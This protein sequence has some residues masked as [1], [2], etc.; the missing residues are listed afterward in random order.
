M[1]PM[2]EY[3]PRNSGESFV[4]KY[5]DYDFFPTPWHFHPEYE[6]VQVIESTGMRF[7][8]DH[9][10]EF[11]PGDMVLI[12]PYL[13]HTY[14]ND[15]NYHL[16]AAALRAKSIVI[17]FREDSFGDNFLGL[18]ETQKVSN[19]LLRSQKG[20]SITGKTNAMVSAK[21]TELL[22]AKGLTRWLLLMEVLNL[23][24]E[25]KDLQEICKSLITGQ[26]P[27]ETKRMNTILK[28]VLNNF[29]R[30]INIAEVADLANMAANS[31]SR[32]F[33]QRTRKSFTSFVNEVR[34]NYGADLLIKTSDSVTQICFECGFNNLSNFNRQFRAIYHNS[35]LNF[36][37]LYQ[38]SFV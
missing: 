34:L 8:G 20:L 19:L 22:T 1:K 7:I 2:L 36:R 37:K 27:A 5:F 10:S 38:N 25:S 3:L 28:F 23:L 29:K 30:E 6:L 12:G 14:Q 21:L 33:S 4:T 18:P 11:S 17:H 16:G 9:V 26:N 15:V 32:Y 24:S 13:P 35:P 31:F